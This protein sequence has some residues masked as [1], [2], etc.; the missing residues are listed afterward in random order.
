MADSYD[1][2]LTG[3]VRAKVVWD[4]QNDL[5][6]GLT[7][8]YDDVT[9][10]WTVA[11]GQGDDQCEK[12]WYARRTV[13][14]ATPT[15]D[16]DLSGVLED[17]FGQSV[18]FT[19]IKVIYIEN[20][21]VGD[22]EDPETFTATSGEDLLVGGAGAVGNAIATILD[23]NQDAQIRLRAGGI[24]LLGAPLDGYTVVGGSEDVLRIEHDGSA[25]SGDDITYD[26][27]IKGY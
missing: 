1:T 11:D 9:Y 24:L 23:G 20:K 10:A 18:V 26:I 8:D 25:A 22:G 21:G 12:L 15:D 7:R 4:F 16:L 19:K 27:V 2:T 14:L 5:E 6:I 13:T 3:R 17:P